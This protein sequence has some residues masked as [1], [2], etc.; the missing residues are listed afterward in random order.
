MSLFS[1]ENPKTLKTLKLWQQCSKRP[2]TFTELVERLNTLG[3]E[4]PIPELGELL[5][6]QICFDNN[7]SWMWKF[8]HHAL[9]LRLLFPLQIFSLLASMP[10]L[11]ATLTLT[12]CS[13]SSSPITIR[14]LF[15]PYV[16]SLLQQQVTNPN[17]TL[18][19]FTQSIGFT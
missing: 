8:M 2:A 19:L 1:F 9:S 13:L 14:V 5:I 4:L 3:I 11:T 16:V 17:L 6:S 15:S 7:H 12:L 18:A 10:Y